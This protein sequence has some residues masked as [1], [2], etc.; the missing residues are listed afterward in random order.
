MEPSSN[1]T[2]HTDVFSLPNEVVFD[3]VR[4]MHAARQ[5]ASYVPLD[6]L[7]G[8]I[9]ESL[10]AGEH[11]LLADLLIAYEDRRLAAEVGA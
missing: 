7:A 2:D 5:E 6:F 3:L 9:A 8:I 11:L 10:E 4:A 1:R